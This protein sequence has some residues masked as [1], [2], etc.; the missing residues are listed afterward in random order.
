MNPN[1]PLNDPITSHAEETRASTF[2]GDVFK[3]IIT[4]LFFSGMIIALDTWTKDLVDKNLPLGKGWLPDSLSS[5]SPYF[6]IIHLQNKGTA[7]GLFHDQNQINLVIS[8]VAV[9]ASL[10][11]IFIFPKIGKEERTLRVALILQLAGAVGN[12]ISRIRYGYVLDFISVGSF[13]VFNV[14]DSSITIGLVIL[15]IGMIYQEYRDRK[16]PN[17]SDTNGDLNNQ[18]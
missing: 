11:I 12:L 17:P 4:L 9:L 6:R 5:L 18:I 13:P 3:D 1:E 15:L 14:A 16:V 10:F 8:A 2:S 7:F